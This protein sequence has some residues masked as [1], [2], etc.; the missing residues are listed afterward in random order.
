MVVIF[1]FISLEKPSPMMPSG[2]G[3]QN[4]AV[5][6]DIFIVKALYIET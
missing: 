1:D 3:W 4:W 2:S 6:F 5:R